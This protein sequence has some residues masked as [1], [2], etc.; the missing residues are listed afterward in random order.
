CFAYDKALARSR[1]SGRLFALDLVDGSVRW[2]IEVG[3]GPL[4]SPVGREIGGRFHLFIAARKGLLQALDVSGDAPVALWTY[5]LPQEVLGSPVLEM[6]TD[7][8]LL[9]LGSKFGNLNAIDALTGERRWQRMAGSWIDNSAAV[10]AVGGERIVFVGSHDYSVYAFRARDGELLWQRRLGG[11][12]YSA[13]SFFHLGAAPY[14][15]VASLDNHLYLLDARTGRVETS[16]FTGA[17][18]WD[19]V[20]KGETL[21]GSP[22]VFEAGKETALVHGSFNNTVYVLPVEGEC[23]LRTKVRS[24]TGLWLG[25]SAVLMLFLLVV[26]PLVLFLPER[27]S[28]NAP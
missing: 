7:R 18:I 13:P 8:P 3:H 6:D 12:I 14:A 4:S 20:S 1:Q 17:P 22:A 19:K 24:A 25:L 16:Y 28:R 5:Q 27:K 23:S 2:S 10:G 15:A 26:L 21:W 9:F 11:E